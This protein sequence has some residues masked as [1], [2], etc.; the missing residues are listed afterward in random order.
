M[1][2]KVER[3]EKDARY[4]TLWEPV[5]LTPEEIARA[6][7]QGPPK[8]RWDYLRGWGKKPTTEKEQ[9]SKDEEVNRQSTRVD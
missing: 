6:C 9:G 3:P 4:G 7:M 8:K 1:A 2:E 5:D